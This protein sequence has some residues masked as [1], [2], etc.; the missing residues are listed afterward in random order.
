MPRKKEHPVKRAAKRT[1]K[2]KTQRK[3]DKKEEMQIIGKDPFDVLRFVVMTEKAIQLIETQNKLVFI[4]DRR[5]DRT[6]VR[7]AI[8]AAFQTKVKNV[9]TAIDQLGRKKA[10]IRFQEAGQAG[11]IA[12]RLGII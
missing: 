4:V 9:N 6:E 8:E 11:E 12:I 1:A 10:F 2:E 3:A 7:N 5:K